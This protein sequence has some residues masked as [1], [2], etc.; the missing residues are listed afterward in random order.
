MSRQLGNDVFISISSVADAVVVDADKQK[1][2]RKIKLS[3]LIPLKLIK[4]ENVDTTDIDQKIK[5]ENAGTTDTVQKIKNEKAGTS[6]TDQK[7]NQ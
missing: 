1:V 4:K 5:E 3:S 6:V 7:K 2:E